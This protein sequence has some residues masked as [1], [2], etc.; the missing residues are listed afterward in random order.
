[1][2]KNRKK[3]VFLQFQTAYQSSLSMTCTWR[4]PNLSRTYFNC[5]EGQDTCDSLAKNNFVR[6]TFWEFSVLCDRVRKNT[7]AS[8]NCC[9]IHL[10]SKHSREHCIYHES[11]LN[12]KTEKVWHF[13]V[14]YFIS[15]L[16]LIMF[17]T[18]FF[19]CRRHVHPNGF[20][21]LLRTLLLAVKRFF[22]VP[23][24]K[25]KRP[26]KLFCRTL[27]NETGRLIWLTHFSPLT[28]FAPQ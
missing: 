21:C 22:H 23:W 14:C 19:V 20:P 3:D 26:R 8:R 6:A 7:E 5:T 18:I 27:S 15:L 17:F 10:K 9:V 4:K 1:M 25:H 2:S 24:M 28:H 13:L 11:W 12:S 16:L